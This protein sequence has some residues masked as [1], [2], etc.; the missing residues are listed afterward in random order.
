MIKTD[1]LQK[2]VKSTQFRFQNFKNLQIKKY[3]VQTSCSE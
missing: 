1:N 3:Q 2:L